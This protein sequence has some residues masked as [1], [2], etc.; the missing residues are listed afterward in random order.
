M[1]GESSPS[2]T[3]SNLSHLPSSAAGNTRP[4]LLSVARV[5]WVLVVATTLLLNLIALPDT[6]GSYF[7]FRP[8]VLQDLHRLGFSPTLYGTLSALENVPLQLVYLGLGLL[9]FWRR[10]NDPV[11]LFCSFVLVTFGNTLWLYDFITG[12]VVSSLAANALLRTLTLVMLGTGETSLVIFFY[13]FP[14]GRFV[15]RWTRWASLLV[16]SYWMAVVFFPTLPSQQDPTALPFLIDLFWLSAATAQ[17]YRYWRVSTLRERQQTKWAV[18]GLALAGLFLLITVPISVLVVP[19]SISNDPVL[20]GLNPIF[21]VA[22]LFIPIFITVAVWRARLWDI[23][24]LINRTLVYG[25]LTGLL[26]ALYTGFIIGLESLGGA[27][28]GT[29]NEP[30]A[31]VISTL[32]IAALFQ[33]L[34]SRVQSLIDRRF[35][36]RKYDA[37]KMLEAFSARLRQEVDLEQLRELLLSAVTDTMHPDHVSLWLR[38]TDPPH[39]P[40]TWNAAQ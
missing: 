10:S 14:S 19:P 22:L 20:W 6:F 37:E 40:T 11:A 35:Y 21:Q 26:G 39:H 30:V 25:S 9:L 24:V 32:V 33:P 34:R 4:R 2:T 5:A 7:S 31:L 27:L 18:F 1:T 12:T 38:E 15:P 3:M 16:A 29:A 36:R 23:D 8:E 13:V 17:I 28:T